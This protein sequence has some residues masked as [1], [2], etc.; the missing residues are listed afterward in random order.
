MFPTFDHSLPL[1]EL[2]ARACACVAVAK[3]FKKQSL[4]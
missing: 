1:F 2:T 4:I 3:K